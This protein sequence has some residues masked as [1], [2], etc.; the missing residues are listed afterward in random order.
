MPT[1]SGDD[2]DV[3]LVEIPSCAVFSVLD[4]HRLA[5]GGDI[6]AELVRELVDDPSADPIISL[7]AFEGEEAV[8][9]V[10]LTSARVEGVPE[11]VKAM[12]LAPLAV[13]P[14][15]QR[16][17]VGSELVQAALRNAKANGTALV[18][19]LGY[20]DYYPRFGFVPA[21]AQGLDAPFP[22]PVEHADAWMVADLSGVILGTVAGRVRTADAL[23]RAEYWTE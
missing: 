3:R 17:G 20:P 13:V 12:L 19:V 14:S 5:F 22:I 10:L 8:G 15:R 1:G 16:R 9:H 6:E 4:V 2:G 23:M 7:A 11:S 18:F 21:G